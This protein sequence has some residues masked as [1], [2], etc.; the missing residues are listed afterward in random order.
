MNPTPDLIRAE[1]AHAIAGVPGRLFA[2]RVPPAPW[3]AGVFANQRWTSEARPVKGY[4]S[5]ARLT[6]EMRFD[7]Q[8][9]NGQ[10]DFAITGDIK[11][12]R[13]QEIAG[14]CLHEDI[15]AVFPEL[16]HL[17]RWHLTGTA[18]PMHYLA[19]TLYL[20][21]DRDCHGRRKG[22]PSRW[23]HG[24]RFNGSPVTFRVSEKFFAW[25]E[26]QRAE[27]AH[28][29]VAAFDHERD[30][31]TFGTH[32]TLA[33]FASTWAGCPFRDEAQAQ[34]FAHALNT[35]AVEPRRDAVGFAEGKAR[36]LDA[37]R[38]AA[39]WPDATDEQL[40]APREEL[41]AALEARLPALLAAFRA[42]IERA[43]FLW[44]CPARAEG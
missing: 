14:G 5:G 17:I 30:A 13:G 35:C 23:E 9:R 40:C 22:E 26:A 12:P 32:Y 38:R 8:C 3:V 39:V 1:C 44:E 2:L 36:E 11:G 7:D 37:A 18:G 10:N 43:G 34:E 24:Y 29:W 27:K 31:K 19:N 25:V 41:R 16:A 21:G 15:A 20:A 6:V 33:G 4:G 28:F 42:D